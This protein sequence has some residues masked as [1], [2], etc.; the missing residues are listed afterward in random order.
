M[1]AYEAVIDSG[2]A[3][4]VAALVVAAP[5]VF[6]AVISIQNHAKLTELH[7]TLNS[8]LTELL[9][10][11]AAANQKIGRADQRR[12]DGQVSAGRMP[13]KEP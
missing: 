4:I 8:R 7:L 6:A 3:T 12:D 9:T 10:M 11:I 13:N 2:T 1:G 5:G